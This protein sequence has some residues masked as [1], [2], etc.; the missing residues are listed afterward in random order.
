M[1]NAKGTAHEWSSEGA[2][3]GGR[4]EGMVVASDRSYMA[5][6]GIVEAKRK[7]EIETEKKRRENSLH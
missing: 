6:I 5:Q 7:R 4:K 2:R 1:A 3:A